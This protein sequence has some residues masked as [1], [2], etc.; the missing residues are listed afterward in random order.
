MPRL[1]GD[2]TLSIS[3][4]GA[5]VR[6]ASHMVDVDALRAE[7]VSAFTFAGD[8]E[9]ARQQQAYMKSTMPYFGV[10]KGEV[11]RI[12]KALS[13]RYA[14]TTVDEFHDVTLAIWHGAQHRE[15]R[16]FC[17]TWTGMTTTKRWQTPALLPMYTEMI[18]TG[19]WWDHVDWLAVHRVGTIL[20]NARDETRRVLEVFAHD[21]N[22]WKRRTAILS[23]NTHGAATD[24]AWLCA[25]IM[26]SIDSTE[27]FLR[28]AIGWALRDYA[29][30]DPAAVLAFVAAHAD[31]L[32]GLSKREALKH[33]PDDIKAPLLRTPG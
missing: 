27:F 30:V 32:S 25:V 12:S 28:K 31:R 15:E 29:D 33:I 2:G 7:L 3:A 13:R 9:R 21:D 11:Q 5:N 4:V 23:Q 16:Y 17:E 8:P 20:L 19:A 1:G 10:P 22:L 18:V 24:F 6:Y 14:P 26:P